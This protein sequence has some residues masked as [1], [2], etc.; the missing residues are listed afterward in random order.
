MRKLRKE[1]LLS[2]DDNAKKIMLRVAIVV[3]VA[4]IILTGLKLVPGIIFGNL[5]VISDA[6]HSVADLVTS[7][8]IIV[9]VFM[10]SP[11][12]DKKHNYGHEKVEPLMVLLFSLV[13]FGVVG[14]LM[15]KGITG[16][17]SPENSEI[18]I[19]L[20]TITVV[21]IAVKEALF[22]YNI[23]YAKKIKSDILR[24]SAWHSRADSLSSVAVLAGLIA[25]IFLDTNIVESIAVLIVALLIA[26][27]AVDI[28]RTA[29]KQ[30]TDSAA[31]DSVVDEIKKTVLE[32]D[33]VE[34]IDTLRTR[35]F[36]KKIY[37]EIVIEVDG[38]IIVSAAHQ[39]S[40]TV[41]DTLEGIESL[42]IK[43]CTVSIVPSKEKP[44]DEDCEI[45]EESANKEDALQ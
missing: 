16:I 10:A 40:K 9:V 44:Q 15:Y 38:N 36:G 32:V 3:A 19:F 45:A 39:I 27:I 25:S 34:S 6:I 20:I 11:K 26:K 30:L 41:H 31:P 12:R 21:S 42:N 13:L 29:V 33:G 22:W 23:Y 7:L 5:S 4:N 35:I 43:H 2:Q 24:A 8:F 28:F 18:N 37:V 1:N 14:L 17:I